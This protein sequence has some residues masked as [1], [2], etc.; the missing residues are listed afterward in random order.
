MKTV[1]FSVIG[2]G[3]G[4]AIALMGLQLFLGQPDLSAPATTTVRLGGWGSLT[5]KTLLQGVLKRFE[6]QHPQI[7]VKHEVISDQYMD[8]IKTRL[9]GD[10]APD[11][12]YLDLPEAPFLIAQEVLEPLD[13]YIT[14]DFDL[15]DFAP[16]LLNPFS[17][18]DHIYGLPKDYS[19]LVLF[20]N[21]QALAEAGLTEPPQTWTQLRQYAKQLTIDTNGDGR[22]DQYG[23]G[24]TP[25]LAHQM[26]KLKA[27]GGQLVDDRGYATFATNASLKGLN[28]IVDQ[29]LQDKSTVQPSDVGA[30]FEGEMFGL[31]K[32]AMVISGNW[33]IPYL[34]ETF[35]KLDF[36]TAE[37]PR[38]NDK[39]GT[40]LY[41]VAYVLNRQSQHKAA[42]WELIAYLTGKEGMEQWTGT[43]FALP[44]RQSV[45]AK[46]GY[47]QG[48][49]RRALVAGVDYA[50]PWQGGEHL[51][52]IST[53][54]DNQFL[55]VLLG[56]QPLKL[57]MSRA[58][59][60]VNQQIRANE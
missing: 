7:K 41:T 40:M 19:T 34:E 12:F 28:F 49:L 25:K 36:G 4:L 15:A 14:P 27:F 37:L 6:A 33:S 53:R 32:V 47:D 5:E 30:T 21:K 8:V 51:A 11:V 17:D 50:T 24:L 39:P 42:A 35:P 9:I 45:A 48:P 31:G 52:T 43:G 13:A 2:L 46:L 29:Y 57:A 58:Q 44:T 59:R 55:S 26:Y 38:I 22:I 10:A 23:C 1:G 18:Q 16:P 3:L 54:F 56:N 60:N 20:Y